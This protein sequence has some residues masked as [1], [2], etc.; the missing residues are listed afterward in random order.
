MSSYIILYQYK[1]PDIE[2]LDRAAGYS[3]REGTQAG[4]DAGRHGRRQ[5]GRQERLL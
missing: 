3:D 4:M 2:E 1:E 5:T